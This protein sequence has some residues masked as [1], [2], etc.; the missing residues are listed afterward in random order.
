MI[1]N[2][3]NLFNLYL[4]KD[5]ELLMKKSYTESFYHLMKLLKWLPE[6]YGFKELEI[7]GRIV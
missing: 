7:D 1:P 3:V 5:E 2:E 4:L 6:Y